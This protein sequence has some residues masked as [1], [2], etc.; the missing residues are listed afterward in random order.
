MP[1]LMQRPW[2]LSVYSFP[3]DARTNYHELG[4]LKQQKFI[5]LQF[6]R[7]KSQIKVTPG[8]VLLEAWKESLSHAFPLVCGSGRP[9][10][11]SLGLW[12]HRS[13]LCLCHHIMA[14]SVS[15]HLP[16]R[17]PV[18]GFRATRGHTPLQYDRNL[19]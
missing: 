8:L 3:G 15:S 17:T 2:S 7:P 14:S 12:Q 10:S 5:L 6:W 18:N 16:L 13:S 1:S 11:A 9:S 4:G 19:I